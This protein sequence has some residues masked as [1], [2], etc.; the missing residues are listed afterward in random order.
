MHGI[1][2]R[3]MQRHCFV[4]FSAVSFFIIGVG[5][6]L[7]A[8]IAFGVGGSNLLGL[9]LLAS[10]LASFVLAPLSG[11]L[12]DRYSR[13][14]LT[15]SGQLI[16]AVGLLML[17][18]VQVLPDA[19]S[20]PILLLSAILGAFGYALLAG[21]MS[22]MLQSLIPE[23]ERMGFNMRLSFFNQAGL[24]LGTGVAG[25]AINR[26]GSTTAAA[27]FACVAA[28]V[29]PLLGSL[30]GNTN[31]SRPV[32]GF[33]PLSASREALTY[34]LNEPESLSASVTV[35]LAFAV[36]QIT[37]LLLP[38]F[39]VH[40]LGGG[41]RLFGTL[42]MTAAAAGMAALAVAG[43]QA[44]AR[45]M[46]RA[47]RT[48]LAGAAGSLIVLS[49]VTNPLVAIVLYA[50]A[51]MLWNL[52][53]AAANGH[54][55]TV[56]DSKL[57]GRVQAFTTLLTGGVGALIF[58]LPTLLPNA[59]EAELYMACGVTILLATALLGLWTRRGRPGRS[60]TAMH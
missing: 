52:S 3:A 24:A 32:K 10:S 47:T 44:V 35:G 41:S 55:L 26:L 49:C 25:Y 12:V 31:G 2:S 54:L 50:V 23:T 58:L 29:L 7:P 45:K 5:I 17:A 42:E 34:L 46:A 16:R 33:N 18:P 30:T 13:H 11:Y 6:V 22:G 9:V 39:V 15:A 48:V 4:G 27:L 57:I 59:T 36:I 28:S 20:R 53:R 21:A 43:V 51:G 37:N 19:L 8:W 56:V 60:R 38:G 40:A 1:L 14:T